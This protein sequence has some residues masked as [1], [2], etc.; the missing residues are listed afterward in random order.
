MS[1]DLQESLMRIIKERNQRCDERDFRRFC[2]YLLSLPADLE[3]DAKDIS[4][5]I[6]NFS[7]CD[8]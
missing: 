7:R 1:T 4:K 5:R 6:S 8:G 3:S 2:Q